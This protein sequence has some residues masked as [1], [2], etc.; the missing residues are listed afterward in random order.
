M[1]I[2]ECLRMGFEKVIADVWR[3]NVLTVSSVFSIFSVVSVFLVWKQLTQ[4][5]E[6]QVAP[7]L[8]SLD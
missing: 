7:A 3:F 2:K 5:G 1:F 8:I 6:R 4:S